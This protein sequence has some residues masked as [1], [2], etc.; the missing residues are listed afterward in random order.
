MQPSTDSN[1]EWASKR[2]K[3]CF[4]RVISGLEK[5]GSLRLITLT[6]SDDAPVDIQ[7]SFRKLIMRLRR[8][9][10]VDD[11]IKV[12]ETKNDGRDHI[13]LCFRG[14]FIEQMFLSA[15]W[16][17]IHA[18]PIVDV[19]RVKSGYR[20]KIAVAGY[21]AKY[22]AKEMTRRYSW[23]WGWVYKGF[24]KTWREAKHMLYGYSRFGLH[25]WLWADFLHLWRLH[26]RRHHTREQFLMMLE[27]GLMKLRQQ[28]VLPAWVNR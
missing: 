28:G 26:L 20:T 11:Y 22:M 21:L 15:L 4:H 16:A 6:S 3:R 19:R 1:E 13:H 18:S 8:R 25:A 9:N 14:Q 2:R 10:L 27:G 24:V 23:S 7:R 17:E 5:G 12:I